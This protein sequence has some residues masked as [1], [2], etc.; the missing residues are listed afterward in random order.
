VEE[1][2][3]GASVVLRDGP[4]RATIHVTVDAP[5]YLVLADTWY[6]GWRVT[7]DGEP[8]EMLRANHAFRAVRLGAGTHVVEMAYRPWSAIQGLQISLGTLA[9]LVLG[10]IASE[11]IVRPGRMERS[12][13]ETSGDLGR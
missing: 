1:V 4:N 2:L 11:R 9:M 7:V 10:Y 3:S 13:G 6:P 8:D 5:G 12:A